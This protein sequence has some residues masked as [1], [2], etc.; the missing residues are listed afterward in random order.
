MIREMKVGEENRIRELSAR[1]EYEDQ[2]LWHKQTKPL[3]E[4]LAKASK[5]PISREI[6]AK[7]V[8]FVAEE[9]D[10][11]VGFCWCT[12][13]DRGVDKQGELA[14][15]YVENEYRGKGIGKEL[16]TAAKQLFLDENVEVAFVWTHR[17]NDEAIKLYRDAGFEEVTQIVMAF[18][19]SKH[20]TENKQLTTTKHG[21]MTA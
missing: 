18:V 1:L 2:I 5:I 16:I 9:K 15:F 4:C 13:S 21:D 10:R 14:E 6:K 19:P 20:K 7:S 11:I 8:I 12:I 17:G 3:E